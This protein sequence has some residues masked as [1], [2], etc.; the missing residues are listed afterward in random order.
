MKKLK[1]KILSIQEQEP[2]D[3]DLNELKCKKCGSS[4]IIQ[5][6]QTRCADEGMTVYYLCRKCPRTIKV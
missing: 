3:D 1:Q 5:P 2:K 6:R 4:L